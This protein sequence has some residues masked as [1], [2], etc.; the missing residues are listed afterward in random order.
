[1]RH[2]SA[3]GVLCIAS[4][5]KG[6]DGLPLPSVPTLSTSPFSVTSMVD[7]EA[8][9]FDGEMLEWERLADSGNRNVCRFCST[10]GNRVYP[11]APDM[12]KLTLKPVGVDVFSVFTP[13]GHVWVSEKPNEYT[14]PAGV[15]IHQRQPS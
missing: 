2:V 6:S 12:I 8:I 5:A 4:A 13:S 14:I 15:V 3:Y 10:C 1:M 9:G 7:A 11:D